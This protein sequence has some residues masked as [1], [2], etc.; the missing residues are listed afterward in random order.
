MATFF[1]V[2]SILNMLSRLSEAERDT[3]K[4]LMATSNKPGLAAQMQSWAADHADPRVKALAAEAV[5]EL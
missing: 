3:L 2:P 1:D 4:T 5:T